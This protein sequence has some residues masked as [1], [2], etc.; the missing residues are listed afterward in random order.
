MER[1]LRKSAPAQDQIFRGS[2]SL[3]DWCEYRGFSRGLF[4][5]LEKR[6]LAPR[7]HRAGARRLVSAEADREWLR[8]RESES[9]LQTT[10]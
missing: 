7:T 5:R 2:M 9:E 3:Q 10:A 6:G 8:Q 1:R 4:Y